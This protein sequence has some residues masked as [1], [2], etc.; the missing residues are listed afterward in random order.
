MYSCH[1]FLISSV[2]YILFLSFIVHIFAQY[3]EL[4]STVLGSSS[5][6]VISFCLFIM[7]MEFSR[8]DCWHGLPFHFSSGTPVEFL[9]EFCTMSH[10]SWVTLQDMAHSFIESDKAVIHV[11]SL[12]SFLWLQFS[13]CLPS[14]GEAKRLVKVSLREGLA[15]GKTDSCC[16]G[17]DHAQLIFNPIFCRLV[18]LWSLRVVWLEF[19]SMNYFMYKFCKKVILS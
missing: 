1:L 7:F 5:F 6:H 14:D 4:L 15:S 3:H 18:G 8:Q 17:Q 11:I 10:Q 16:G 9:S 19:R 12:V 13:F 2:R